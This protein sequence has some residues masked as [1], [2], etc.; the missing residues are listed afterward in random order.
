MFIRNHLCLIIDRGIIER[1][2][3]YPI[4]RLPFKGDSMYRE[5]FVKNLEEQQKKA[6]DWNRKIT[7]PSL[8]PQEIKMKVTEDHVKPKFSIMQMERA[9]KMFD[10]RDIIFADLYK[11][12][13]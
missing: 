9:Q 4:Y 2:P 6:D 3:Q 12:A 8:D 11:T 1:C 7:A 10:P 5:S 13:S